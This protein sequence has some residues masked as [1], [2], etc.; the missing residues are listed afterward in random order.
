MGC[1][2]R[3]C[4]VDP[5]GA[6]ID[7]DISWDAAF[8]AAHNGADATGCDGKLARAFDLRNNPRRQLCHDEAENLGCSPKG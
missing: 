2:I 7:A 5:G 1:R 8:G 4:V 3:F 6:D